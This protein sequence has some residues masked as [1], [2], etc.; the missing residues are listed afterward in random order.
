MRLLC[1]RLACFRTLRSRCGTGLGPC[2]YLPLI[3]VVRGAGGWITDWEGDPLGL[4][5]GER[6][7]AAAN[8]SLLDAVIDALEAA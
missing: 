1:L 8:K 3:P 5:S 2:D 6:I 7:I 4:N